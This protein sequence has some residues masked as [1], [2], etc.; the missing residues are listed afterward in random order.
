MLYYFQILLKRANFIIIKKNF[1][2]KYDLFSF[3]IKF[4]ELCYKRNQFVYKKIQFTK[5]S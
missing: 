2:T 4:D 1:L 3:I 5:N